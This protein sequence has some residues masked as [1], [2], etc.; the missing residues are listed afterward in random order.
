MM[1]QVEAQLEKLRSEEASLRKRQE[2]ALRVLRR[3]LDPNF[4]LELGEEGLAELERRL[5]ELELAEEA[6][7]ASRGLNW[8]IS[9]L[10][11]NPRQ[12]VRQ[13]PLRCDG[14]VK[15]PLRVRKVRKASLEKE[16][17]ELT[18]QVGWTKNQI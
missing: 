17:N 16:C 11:R 13:L 12:K 18:I 6:Q 7:R 15:D 4:V 3:G 2:I 9:Q 10:L 1:K 5:K 14:L 8:F